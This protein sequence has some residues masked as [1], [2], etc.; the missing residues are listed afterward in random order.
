MTYIGIKVKD[1]GCDCLKVVDIK[2]EDDV[3]KGHGFKKKKRTMFDLL[4]IFQM[5]K[6]STV[7]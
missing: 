7:L 4:W 1:N 3:K 2:K 5:L 6:K